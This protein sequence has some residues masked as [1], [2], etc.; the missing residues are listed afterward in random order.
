MAAVVTSCCFVLYKNLLH[1]TTTGFVV[2]RI[3]HLTKDPEVDG[4]KVT[5]SKFFNFQIWSC[6]GFKLSIFGYINHGKY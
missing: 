2:K 5:K 3:L 4:S 6:G 1:G